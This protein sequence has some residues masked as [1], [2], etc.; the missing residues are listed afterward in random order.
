[1]NFYFLLWAAL[2]AAGVYAMSYWIYLVW[3]YIRSMLGL[4]ENDR[5]K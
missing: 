2:V 4:D 5:S 1:M 3:A